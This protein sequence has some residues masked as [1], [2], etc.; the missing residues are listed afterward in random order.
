MINNVNILKTWYRSFA[1]PV[2]MHYNHCVSM[3]VRSIRFP[4]IPSGIGY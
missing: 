3:S 4:H 1:R 2:G